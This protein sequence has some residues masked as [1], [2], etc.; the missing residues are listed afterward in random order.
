[1]ETPISF[2]P[3]RFSQVCPD[4]HS[5]QIA[6]LDKH[7][8]FKPQIQTSMFPDFGE[9]RIRRSLRN[10]DNRN[11]WGFPSQLQFF[12][13]GLKKILLPWGRCCHWTLD[14]IRFTTQKWS[15]QKSKNIGRDPK[16][17]PQKCSYIYYD[18]SGHVYKLMY[19]LIFLKFALPGA[20]CCRWPGWCPSRP[21]S[22]I[23]HSPPSRHWVE[24]ILTKAEPLPLHEILPINPWVGKQHTG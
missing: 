1:M 15:I 5:L 17:M 22:G 13:L 8:F 2:C 11:C 7:S 18:S 16:P 24:S 14:Q 4:L 21:D 10:L 12:G 19:F 6:N 23:R 9:I 3:S 20:R